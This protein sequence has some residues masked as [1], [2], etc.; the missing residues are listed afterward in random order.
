MLFLTFGL[1]KKYNH[2]YI[3][4][5]IAIMKKMGISVS[6]KTYLDIIHQMKS[7]FV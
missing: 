7:F 6:S 5:K 1:F 3:Y 4:K 2:K